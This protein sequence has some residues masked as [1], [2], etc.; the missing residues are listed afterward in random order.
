MSKKNK[1]SWKDIKLKTAIELIQL[2]PENDLDLI[3]S[4]LSIIKNVDPFEIEQMTFDE[5]TSEYEQWDFVGTLPEERKDE[6]FKWNGKRYGIVN[7]AKLSLAQMVDIEELYAAGF[8]ENVHNILSIVYLPVKSYNF[9]TK[10]YTLETYEFNKEVA[11]TFLDLDFDFV[12][13]NL[14]FFWTIVRIYTKNLQDYLTQNNQKEMMKISQLM[15]I[16]LALLTRN[17]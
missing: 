11:D 1:K 4:R 6:T 5:I 12:Y 7:F 8:L 14:L 2:S 3:V 16:D 15:G 17:E 13:G 10:K 9:I